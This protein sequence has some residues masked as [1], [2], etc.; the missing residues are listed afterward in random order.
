MSGQAYRARSFKSYRRSR[1]M[2]AALLVLILVLLQVAG[3]NGTSGEAPNGTVAGQ[4]TDLSGNPLAEA[5]VAVP[6]GTAAVPEKTAITDDAGR[7]IWSLPT[8]TF[9]IAVFKD[10]YIS[11]TVQVVVQSQQTSTLNFQLVRQ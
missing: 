8:G 7:Y 4:V 11:Q 6:A 3:C 10:G 1:S 9:T 2:A 5:V